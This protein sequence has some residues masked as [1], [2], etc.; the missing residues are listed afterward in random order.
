VPTDFAARSRRRPFILIAVWLLVLQA[1][2]AGLAAARSGP[3]IASDP[4]V[5]HGAGVG[6]DPAAPDSAKFPHLCCAYCTS[7][8]P[9][10]PPP[11]APQLE[12]SQ[13]REGPPLAPARFTVVIAPGAVRAGQSQ[14]PPLLA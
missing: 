8:A 12:R 7:A 13:A 4:V 5:C 3:A 11:V 9:A 1:F 10:L 14:A 6:A 2:V